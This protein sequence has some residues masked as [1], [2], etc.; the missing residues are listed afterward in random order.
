MY[1]FTTFVWFILMRNKFPLSI[2]FLSKKRDM[3]GAGDLDSSPRARS[4]SHLSYVENLFLKKTKQSL[5][6]Q[7][8]NNH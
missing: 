3:V 6:K 1:I 7:Q 5:K 2:C 8:R 4:E